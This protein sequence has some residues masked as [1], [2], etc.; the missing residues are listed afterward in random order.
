[1]DKDIWSE[2]MANRELL[3]WQ[4]KEL[5]PNIVF[6]GSSICW[7]CLSDKHYGLYKT[8]LQI[9][10]KKLECKKFDGVT[11]YNAYHPSADVC[12]QQRKG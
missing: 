5:S 7:R 3:E 9:P 1:V 12:R 4:I 8:L 11:F 10:I 2:F 6:A